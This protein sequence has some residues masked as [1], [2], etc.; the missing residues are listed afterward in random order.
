MK[1]MGIDDLN[2]HLFETIEMLKNNNDPQASKNEKIDI[3]T[4]KTIV[5]AGKVIVEGF[6]VKANVLGMLKNTENPN[7][8]RQASV[9]AGIF[10][11]DNVKLI[12]K[13]TE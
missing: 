4:A 6:K 1:K 8:M 11:S 5:S 3:E 7:A 2:N 13:Q 9:D 12:D 10:T